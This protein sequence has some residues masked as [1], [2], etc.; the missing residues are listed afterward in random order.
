[1]KGVTTKTRKS[2]IP[3]HRSSQ[4][5]VLS[6]KAAL[7]E[8]SRVNPELMAGHPEL[9]YA[10]RWR[11]VNQEVY[12]QETQQWIWKTRLDFE[13]G[14]SDIE[15]LKD[16]D[17]V[18]IIFENINRLGLNVEIGYTVQSPPSSPA[19]TPKERMRDDLNTAVKKAKAENLAQVKLRPRP[20]SSRHQLANYRALVQHVDLLNPELSEDERRRR[21]NRL[22]TAYDR[23]RDVRPNF[24][25][26]NAQ[27]TEARRIKKA[28]HRERQKAK[29]RGGPAAAL[30]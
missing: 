2:A 27:L 16:D 30:G 6:H 28:A 3:Y 21:A 18:F 26:S 29:A 4:V 5:T 19:D 1:M 20:R 10:R 7:A 11:L 25:D 15:E 14:D 13:S 22:L 9:R 24:R 17:D 23:L 12:E 8:L